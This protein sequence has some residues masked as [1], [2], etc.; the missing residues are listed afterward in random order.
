MTEENKNTALAVRKQE[1][2][3]SPAR[4]IQIHNIVD[5]ERFAK[6]AAA[7]GFFKDSRDMAQAMIKVQYGLEIGVA[8]V[9]AMNGIHV[10]EGKMAVSA[11]L[12]ASKIQGSGVYGYRL[13]KLDD[14]GCE[15]DFLEHGKVIGRVTFTDKDA[16]T[17]ELTGKAMWK[18]YKRNMLFS[19]CISNA[20]KWYA[21]GLFG[22]S[23]YTPEE[24]ASAD[25]S[26]Q[27]TMGDAV[28]EEAEP[29]SAET[30]AAIKAELDR[31]GI[32]KQ[33]RRTFLDQHFGKPPTTQAEGLAAL[34][35][36]ED[37]KND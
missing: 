33:F 4:G 31:L 32:E 13:V 23:V 22:C 7:S 5:L 11:G 30:T 29:V 3:A 1:A 12:I 9:A 6:A 25:V 8:P 24:I 15:I 20:Q 37:M 27:V 2:M 14:T 18:K 17:A 28:V 26:L 10:I 16:Q 21:P 35:K 34:A 36:L 19:R